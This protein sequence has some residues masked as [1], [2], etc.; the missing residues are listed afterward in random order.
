MIMTL[1][2]FLCQVPALLLGMTAVVY[3]DPARENLL[4]V[5][6]TVISYAMSLK[7]AARMQ[8]HCARKMKHQV[9]SYYY[10]TESDTSL[11]VTGKNRI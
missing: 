1:H 10:I 11:M 3:Q 4:L 7:I 2:V 9:A 5:T 8:M 6:A